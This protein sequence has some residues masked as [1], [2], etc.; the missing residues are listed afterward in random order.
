MPPVLFCRRAFGDFGLKGGDGDGGLICT[1]DTKSFTI[2]PDDAFVILAC[3]G[4]WDVIDNQAA[5]N[6]V[7]RQLIDTG[8]TEAAA[9]ALVK[10]SLEHGS[11]DNISVVVVCFHQRPHPVSTGPR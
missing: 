3:D 11:V 6:I 10:K 7:A 1:P 2:Q 8:S 4:V 5:V 9:D